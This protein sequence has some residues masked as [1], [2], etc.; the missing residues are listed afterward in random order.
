MVRTESY[1]VRNYEKGIIRINL[2]NNKFEYC[3]VSDNK[4]ISKA[5]LERIY[6]L[7]IPPIWDNVWIS[8]DK[9][10]SIQVVGVDSKGRKQYLY[11]KTHIEESEKNKFL[12]LF[13]FIKAIP[14]LE[15]SMDEDSQIKN[16]YDINRV[17]TT[18]LFLVKFLHIRV[19]KEQYARH[20]KSY[21]ITSLKK[22]HVKLDGDYIKLRFKGKS[23]KRLSFNLYHPELK[24]HIKLL[25]KL[26]GD[27]LFQYINQDNKIFKVNDTDLNNYI[28]KNMGSK[29]TAKDFRTYAANIHFIQALLNETKKRT[30]KNE[31]VIKKNLLRALKTTAH[32]LRHTK[33]ISKKSY[34]MNFCIELYTT[35]PEYFIK[36][37]YD[38][39]N[40]V[41]LDLLKMYKQTLD[42][43]V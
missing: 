12:R 37:K 25:L 20:N 38:D 17:I 36:R 21:G 35:N 34:V 6:N 26:E 23:N 41:L 19:G 33:A 32:Y 40:H 16:P 30:P 10:S 39:P 31:K 14:K 15:K 11:H 7:R 22:S 43:N 28:K 2:G 42:V 4:P 9:N 29:F 13:D 8:S 27:K 18:M 1:D 3:Y 24:K 5:D